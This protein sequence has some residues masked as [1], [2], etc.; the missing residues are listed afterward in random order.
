MRADA[1]IPLRDVAD[2]L[3]VGELL[4]FSVLDPQGRRL[5][6]EGRPLV[7]EQ[8]V[9][10]LLER[11]G[12]VDREQAEAFRRSR[13]VKPAAAA[14]VT[15][16]FAR[17]EQQ[18]WAYDGLVRSLARGEAGVAQIIALADTVAGLVDRDADVALFLCMRQDD[19]R[20]A[21]YA[22]THSLHSMVLTLLTARQMGWPAAQVNSVSRAALTMNLSMLEL[23][24]TMAEQDSPPTGRQM[25]L[26]RAHPAAASKML[27]DAGVLDADWLAAVDDHHEQVGGGGYPR[28]ISEVGGAAQLVRA[29]DV[30]MAKV[31]PRAGR[32]PMVPQ[33]A[34]RQLFQQQPGSA[35]AM[36]LIKAVGVHPPGSLV[37]LQSGEVAVVTH[38]PQAGRAAQAATL[39]NRQGQPSIDTHRRDTAQPEFAITAAVTD[40]S[41]FQRVLPE[42]VYGL[43]PAD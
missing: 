27:R 12:L 20:F 35:L 18:V 43:I 37:R 33:L 1:L 39:S 2:L 23:Q 14:A 31:S 42:R 16:L 38:R 22:L 6:I 7:S 5:L 30:F 10:L 15:T 34:A 9:E 19:R 13:G 41:L 28:G 26:I 21:L 29:A 25:E 24:A 11:G 8:Q 17:W 36:S 4:P 40:L 32:P 3:V